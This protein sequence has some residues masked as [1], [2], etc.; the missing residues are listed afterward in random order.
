MN[1][2]I[3][4]IFTFFTLIFCSAETNNNN[5]YLNFKLPEKYIDDSL[6][7][8]PDQPIIEQWWRELNDTILTELIN[9]ALKVNWNLQEAVKNLE[10]AR[11]LLQNARSAYFPAF[12]LE[13]GWMRERNSKNISAAAALEPGYTSYYSGA[14]SASWEID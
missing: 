3:I 6:Y 4:L 13:G 14:I 1:R 2:V 12:D 8:I 7:V 9:Q 10:V 11:A 5:K